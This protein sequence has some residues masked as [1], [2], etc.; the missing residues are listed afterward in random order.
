[1]FMC[2]GRASAGSPASFVTVHGS[3]VVKDLLLCK[4]NNLVDKRSLRRDHKQSGP[5]HVCVNGLV[6]TCVLEPQDSREN[7]ETSQDSVPLDRTQADK[8]IAGRL[9]RKASETTSTNEN[10][11]NASVETKRV[12]PELPAMVSYGRG[13]MGGRG[14]VIHVLVNQHFKRLRCLFA[15]V[16]L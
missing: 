15:C 2:K 1:M 8:K 5:G 4:L 14:M 16:A 9:S 11:H 6:F 7:S 13:C 3:K 10:L 12:L